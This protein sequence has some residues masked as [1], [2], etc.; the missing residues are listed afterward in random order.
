MALTDLTAFICTAEVPKKMYFP[1]S[2]CLWRM[3]AQKRR[4]N[5]KTFKMP[6]TLKASPTCPPRPIFWNQFGTFSFSN[7]TFFGGWKMYHVVMS[8]CRSD[9]RWP[10]MYFFP[11]QKDAS[12]LIRSLSDKWVR[13]WHM[14]VL[15]ENRDKSGW[16]N[17]LII[18]RSLLKPNFKRYGRAH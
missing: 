18:C 11:T 17:F 15:L 5:S 10:I 16:L 2:P 8:Q 14:Q 9:S 1:L 12:K 4:I 3:T 6:D 7:S 13:C